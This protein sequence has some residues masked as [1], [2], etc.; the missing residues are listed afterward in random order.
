MK[1]DIFYNFPLLWHFISLLSQHFYYEKLV[2]FMCHKLIASIVL[3]FHRLYFLNY[4][5]AVRFS[6]V[7]FGD[8]RALLIGY[9]DPMSYPV[10]YFVLAIGEYVIT[11]VLAVSI[12]RAM[13]QLV[14]TN[15]EM[16]TS[17]V[18]RTNRK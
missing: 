7:K 11:Q 14:E 15:S 8:S 3:G 10:I 13:A 12:I 9:F 4:P 17:Q 2:K 6:N 18:L 16:T 5:H 1:T